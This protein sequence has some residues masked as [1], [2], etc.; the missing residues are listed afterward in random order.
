MLISKKF[1]IYFFVSNSKVGRSKLVRVRSERRFMKCLKSAAKQNQKARFYLKE[2]IP[3]DLNI[4]VVERENFI[5]AKIDEFKIITQ[6]NTPFRIIE[7][8]DRY[9]DGIERV[10]DVQQDQPTKD[11]CLAKIV[12]S[13]KTPSLIANYLRARP[14]AS[15]DANQQEEETMTTNELLYLVD[16]L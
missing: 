5:K 4:Y 2:T 8:E 6:P 13:L 12:K 7:I 10:Y 1:K 15:Q 9:P 14:Q 11:R 16:S 3:E